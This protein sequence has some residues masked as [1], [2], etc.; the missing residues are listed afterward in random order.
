ML[1]EIPDFPQAFIDRHMNWHM[2]MP[3]DGR[4]IAQGQPGSG[5]EFLDFHHQFLIDVKNWYVIQ[6]GADT[7]KLTA[8]AQ[9]PND[10]AQAHSPELS[11]FEAYAGNAS[12]FTTEDALGIYVEAEHNLVHGYVASFYNQPEFALF[13]SCKYFMFHQWHG[14]ID[15]WRGNWLVNHKSALMDLV[16]SK[17]PRKTVIDKP[18]RKESVADVDI[19]HLV[20][21]PKDLEVPPKSPKEL[22]E[23]PQ[24]G[25]AGDP[26]EELSQRL[27]QLETVVHRRAFIRPEERPEVG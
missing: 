26:I 27:A 11:D 13:D 12:H 3:P 5:A 20:D 22:V 10:L 4:I 1:E 2:G 19:K 9:F 15:V 23:A 17:G 7:S 6:P 16:G 8:W 25:G 21:R 18:L 24:P 14:L